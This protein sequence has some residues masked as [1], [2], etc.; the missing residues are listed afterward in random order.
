VIFVDSNIPTYLVGAEHPNKAVAVHLLERAAIEG[1]VLVTDAEV[2]Q[3]VLHRYTAIGRRAAI[4]SA[5]E[6]VLD[7]VDDV[8]V[9]DRQIMER[10]RLLVESD[11]APSAR[12]AVHVAVMRAHEI[13]RVMSF[14]LGL[15]R[16][17]GIE[18]LPTG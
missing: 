12:D 13:S 6:A 5:F 14:D 4:A 11:L 1:E 3:E 2:L 17:E 15:D 10:A 9:I 16:F 7:V 18:R 8:L